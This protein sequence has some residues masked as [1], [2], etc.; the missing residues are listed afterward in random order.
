MIT[1]AEITDTYL[2]PISNERQDTFHASLIGVLVFSAVIHLLAG[3]VYIA[4]LAAPETKIPT[5]SVVHHVTLLPPQVNPEPPQTQKSA[6]DKKGPETADTADTTNEKKVA[7]K[8]TK[9]QINNASP[10][11]T[12]PYIKEL[13][14]A[15]PSKDTVA[16]NAQEADKQ[17]AKNNTEPPSAKGKTA[18]AD[19]TSPNNGVVNYGKNTP[20]NEPD[21]SQ[22][23]KE[24][25][26][27]AI[28]QCLNDNFA[29]I[30]SLWVKPGTFNKRLSGVIKIT[31]DDSGNIIETRIS[32]SSGS[33]PLDLSV[34]EAIQ[35]AKRFSLPSTGQLPRNLNFDFDSDMR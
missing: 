18:S 14:A 19:K 1:S 11:E 28:T 25:I 7:K 29:R 31:L 13:E 23:E 20:K 34:V 4:L 32:T 27:Q 10:I 21:I 24:R 30:L 6:Q 33:L 35:R 8:A 3:V 12:L 15:K 5:E 9:E 2:L 17:P 22:E 26:V 16:S